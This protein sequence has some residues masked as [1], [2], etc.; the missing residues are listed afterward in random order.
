MGAA[1]WS[2]SATCFFSQL[3]WQWKEAQRKFSF[4]E[5]ERKTAWRLTL[6]FFL[7]FDVFSF[8][9]FFWD[10]VLFHLNKLPFIGYGCRGFVLYFFFFWN[11]FS[12]NT[13]LHFPAALVFN[14][15]LSYFFIFS[16][17]KLCQHR[18]PLFIRW[19]C[20]FLRLCRGDSRSPP[21]INNSWSTYS[22]AHLGRDF[23]RK[24]YSQPTRALVYW[25]QNFFAQKSHH[26]RHSTWKVDC[27]FHRAKLIGFRPTTAD[28]PQESCYKVQASPKSGGTPSASTGSKSFAPVAASATQALFVT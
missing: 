14:N 11:L 26:P 22:C 17:L 18:D 4:P 2:R 28:P 20:C 13:H 16:P 7:L 1:D 19:C 9:S 5:K 27:P 15:N 25:F 3:C 8:L 23:P 12:K 10:F 24:I 6:R 21:H